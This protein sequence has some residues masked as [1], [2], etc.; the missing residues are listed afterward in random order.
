MGHE[1]DGRGHQ[2]QH[3]PADDELPKVPSDGDVVRLGA[4]LEEVGA[5]D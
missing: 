4:E 1:V 2:R 3:R 5:E